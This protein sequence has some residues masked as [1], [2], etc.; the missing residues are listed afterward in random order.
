MNTHGYGDA[1]TMVYVGGVDATTCHVEPGTY[2]FVKIVFYNN[3]GFDWKM[4]PGAIEL[5]ETAYKVF[6]NANSI[7]TNEVTAVQYPSKYNFMKPEIPPEIRDYVTLT[8]SQH[9]MDVSPQFFD[10]TFNNILT[11]KDALEGHYF[12]CLNVS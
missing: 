2:T 4:K 12:Y 7:N 10:L 9:V 1:A 5:N 11:L 3:A 6:L 8:P